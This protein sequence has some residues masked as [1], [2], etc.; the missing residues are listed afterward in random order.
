MV[1]LDH[2]TVYVGDWDRWNSNGEDIGEFSVNVQEMIIHENY[3]AVNGISNDVCLLKV[4][5]LSDQKFGFN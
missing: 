4:A 1:S 3:G 2:L 5:T